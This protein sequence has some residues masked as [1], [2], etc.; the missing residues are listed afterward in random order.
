MKIDGEYTFDAPRALVWDAL[1]DPEVL[2]S[3]L[4]GADGLD[5]VGEDEYEGALKIKVGPVQGKFKGHIQIED[6]VDLESYNMK[7]DGKGAPGFV[8]AT[9]G[10]QLTDAD[11]NKTHMVYTGDAKVGGRIASVGQRL[12]DS[13]AKAIIGQSLDALNEY[14]K[15]QAAKQEVVEKVA[16]T[17]AT[18]E[19][20]AKTVAAE[21]Q[22]YVPPTQAE[23][24]AAVSKEVAGNVLKDNATLIAFIVAAI[25]IIGILFLVFS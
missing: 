19:E 6:K 18:E 16:A 10:I 13:S 7:V 4:P 1:Q 2:A 17:G 12:M 5:T 9:G 24:A 20:I 21:V 25:V 11:S 3:I 23:L 14:L 15:I 22:E 8:K